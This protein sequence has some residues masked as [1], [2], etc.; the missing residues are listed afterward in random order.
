MLV[1]TGATGALGRAIV[2]H[3]LTRVP[4][5]Q[6]VASVRDPAKAGDLAARGV[7]VRQADFADAASVARAFA[8]ATK[9]LIVSLPLPTSI[10]V[11]QHRAAIEAA[12][13]AGAGRIL[14]TS[15]MGSDPRS[16]FPPMHTHAATEAMLRDCGVPFTSLRNGFYVASAL[17]M[18]GHGLRAGEVAAP[19]DGPVA[20]TTHG[21]LAEAAAIAMTSDAL[22]G[23]SAPLTAGEALTLEQLAAIASEVTGRAVRRVVVSDDAYR[24]TLVAG[25]LAAPVAD[26]LVGMLAASRH[27]AFSRTDVALGRLIGH[28]PIAAKEVLGKALV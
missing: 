10:A 7:H 2:D 23:I 27:G 20:W 6:I 26:M 12:R 18:F 4:A 28:A 8:G 16:A 24:D 14:Y 21:D 13:A 5:T 15:Q 9:V 25:G 1:V 17:Q 3:L 19:E 11:P 22:D